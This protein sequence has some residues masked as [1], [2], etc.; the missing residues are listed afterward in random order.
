LALALSPRLAR[1]LSTSERVDRRLDSGQAMHQ[2][3]QHLLELL[4]AE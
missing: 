1:V 3:A 2:H 4:A